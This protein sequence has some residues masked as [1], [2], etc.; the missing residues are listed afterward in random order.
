[1]TILRN[2]EALRDYLN[3]QRFRNVQQSLL[4]FVMFSFD[5]DEADALL[6][7]VIKT[8]QPESGDA[9]IYCNNKSPQ[10][11]KGLKQQKAYFN[12]LSIHFCISVVAWQ[13]L[14]HNPLE[15]ENPSKI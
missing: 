14:L 4:S 9:R 2:W 13:D 3:C 10:S 7:S 8:Y 12:R 1:M 15:F 6:S 5:L 11:F